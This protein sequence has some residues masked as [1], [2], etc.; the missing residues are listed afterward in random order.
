[1]K[2]TRTNKEFF[3]SNMIDEF[4]DMIFQKNIDALSLGRAIKVLRKKHKISQNNAAVASYMSQSYLSHVE[5]GNYGL[6]FHK[7]IS[8]SRGMQVPIQEI[9]DQYII[10]LNSL[11]KEIENA[12]L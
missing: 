4:D 12:Q 11:N 6:S 3:G 7:L 9:I 2:L 8:L 10:E 5:K 1:M